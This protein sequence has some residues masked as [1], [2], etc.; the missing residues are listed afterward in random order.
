MLGEP[1]VV[2]PIASGYRDRWRE[3]AE[4][5]RMLS[6]LKK[7]GVSAALLDSRDN[8]EHWRKRAEEMRGFAKETRDAENMLRLLKLA[9]DYDTLAK[10]AAP[11]STMLSS[12]E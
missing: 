5:L 11:P 3:L 6:E 1:T 7:M 10:R 2:V 4:E 8:P 12:D 9:A